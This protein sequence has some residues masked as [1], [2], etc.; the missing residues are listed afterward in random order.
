MAHVRTQLRQAA[1]ALLTGLATTGANSS[2][3][4]TLPL[5]KG[6]GT[7]LAVRTPTERSEDISQSGTQARVIALRVDISAKHADEDTLA[8]LLDQAA[9]EV[10]EAIAGDPTF[11]GL[12]QT[13]DYRGADLSMTGEGEKILGTLS[14]TFDVTL[15]TRREAP[16]AAL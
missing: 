2:T 15:Y 10:E 13:Y 11:S 5:P 9:L 1:L 12:A 7:S 16:S 3:N 14:L 8:D 4:R 6:H